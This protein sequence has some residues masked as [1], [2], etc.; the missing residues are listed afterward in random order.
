MIDSYKSLLPDTGSN[1]VALL[2]QISQQLSNGSQISA[3]TA[4]PP[5]SSFQPSNSAIWV[6]ALWFLSLVM[7]L[8]CALLATLQQHWARRYLRR[9]QPQCAIHTRARLRSFF[10]EG[11]DRFHLAFVVEAIPALLHMSMFLFLTGLV[12]SLFTVHHTIAYIVFGATV[13]CGLA[14][15]AITVMPVLFHDSPYHS[16]LSA[17]FWNVPRKT[18]KA[19]LSAAHYIVHFFKKYTS[20]IREDCITSLSTRISEY[21]EHL[22][23][24][25]TRAAEKAA[26]N[27]HWS[28]DARALSWTLDKS[29]EES[30]LEK[31]VAE[32]PRFT[33]S[34]KVEDP[35]GVLKAAM[36]KSRLHRSLYREITDLLINASDPDLLPSYKELPE[37]VRQRRIGICL[38]ALYVLPQAIEKLLRR[39]ATADADEKKKVRRGFVS[40]LESVPSWNVAL[41]HSN[42]RTR[43]RK[44]NK[45]SVIMAGRCMATVIASRLPD[46]ESY[47]ILT[48]QLG[49]RDPDVLHRYLE[50]PDS[51]RLKNLNHF[52]A[53]TAL[54]FIHVEGTDI[55]L[56]TVRI[57]KSERLKPSAAAEELR[58]E[59]EGL[60]RNIVYRA[61][62]PK[63]SATVRKNARELFSELASLR[64]NGSRPSPPAQTNAPTTTPPDNNGPAITASPTQI[65]SPQ[66]SSPPP[67]DVY[68]SFPSP[69]PYPETPSGEAYPLMSMPSPRAFP[70]QRHSATQSMISTPSRDAS[71]G[72]GESDE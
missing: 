36:L 11:V 5:L 14:Y 12:I 44:Q 38:E 47:S 50:S 1:T 21:K 69:Q 3:Q 59:F 8:F 56:S 13:V 53:N 30:E 61:F 64:G 43:N 62:N 24:S 15:M 41:R 45:E 54:K 70:E 65:P 4:V 18:A 60:F 25:M 20:F 66:V 42:I 22:S 49:I 29:D 52:L 23:V 63:E 57:V 7:A 17:L 55:L 28:I 48:K 31:F 34:R 32:I 46:T 26:K 10:S 58:V 27:Q 9:T 40:L 16:P 37:S 68:I 71:S 39:V 6:N 35:M 2:T 51:L 33:R 67:G 19:L 72:D